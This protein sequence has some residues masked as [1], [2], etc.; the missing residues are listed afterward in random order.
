MT[1]AKVLV[2][3]DDP[4][5]LE[6]LTE[7]LRLE[8]YGVVG[9]DSGRGAIRHL[10]R[11]DFRVA[12]MDVSLPD[13]S[14]LAVLAYIREHMPFLPVIMM[15]GFGSVRDAVKAV[16]T[17]AL[18]YLLK[19]VSEEQ[20]LRQLRNVL[21]TGVKAVQEAGTEGLVERSQLLGNCEAT[22]QLRELVQQTAPTEASVL[23]T[24]EAGSGKTLVARYLHQCSKRQ[25][26][27]FIEVDVMN[28]VDS[29]LESELYGHE[30][31]AFTGA[32]AR[33]TGKFESAQGARCCWT[34]STG[35]RRRCRQA[36]WGCC[37]TG[38]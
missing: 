5:V 36:C 10:D 21:G 29:L 12:I 9:T 13:I 18:D 15:T 17:G 3:D 2:V 19:P 37:R 35:H 26:G 7:A 25:E 23:V 4:V 28:V 32:H 31:G 34:T 38:S 30:E 33:R 8:G 24:G 14:G 6:S 22:R 27:T 11:E 20:L 1:Q 16:R